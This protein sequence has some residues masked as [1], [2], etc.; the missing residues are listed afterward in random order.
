MGCSLSQGISRSETSGVLTQKKLI[1]TKLYANALVLVFRWKKFLLGSEELQR[2][3]QIFRFFS[4]AHTSHSQKLAKL[5][6]PKKMHKFILMQWVHAD[7]RLKTTLNQETKVTCLSIWVANAHFCLYTK[8]KFQ[9]K[10]KC[11]FIH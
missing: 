3:Q 8:S 10:Q 9:D 1:K 7:A 5:W 4:F 2:K 6:M 11:T